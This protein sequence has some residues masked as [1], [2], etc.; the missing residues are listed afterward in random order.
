MTMTHAEAA[1]R[2]GMKEREVAEVEHRAGGDVMVTT[3]EGARTRIA[4]D[5]RLYAA[6]HRPPGETVHPMAGVPL[7]AAFA[8]PAAVVALEH[9]EGVAGIQPQKA[10]P[11]AVTHFGTEQAGEVNRDPLEDDAPVPADEPR[12][13]KPRA[14]GR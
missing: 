10:A 11:D 4:A 7:P 9:P 3:F 8:G 6:G 14:K 2:L 5:G 1:R 13:E 12:R